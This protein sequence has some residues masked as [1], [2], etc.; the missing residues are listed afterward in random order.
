MP[1]AT[2]TPETQPA[3]TL[4]ASMWRSYRDE[5]RMGSSQ[6][7]AATHAFA[8]HPQ[9][10]KSD[11]LDKLR[12]ALYDR[13]AQY[14]LTLTEAEL[15]EQLL[16]EAE[17]GEVPEP[18]SMRAIEADATARVV[19]LRAQVQRLAPEALVDAAVA[20]EQRDCESELA[21][22][23]RALV[24]VERARLEQG[25]R[26]THAAE[27]AE[28]ER[29]ATATAEAAKLEPVIAKAKAEV[30]TAAREWVERVV[31]LRDAVEARAAQV[32][33][34]EPN[35]VMALNSAHFREGDIA[36][37]LRHA[38]RGRIRIGA[39]EAPGRTE[40]LAPDPGSE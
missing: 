24:N 15:R 25:R 18:G 16:A 37:S 39:L 32:A 8:A 34:A 30:D 23:E 9:Y 31:V 6:R 2:H 29:R 5:R 3:G 13:E 22:A 11:T 4:P 7:E 26:D 33:A 35:D 19:E 10:R 12:E 14:G 17:A 1:T 27:Q 20:A 38:L 40:P 21:D 28:A 36:S